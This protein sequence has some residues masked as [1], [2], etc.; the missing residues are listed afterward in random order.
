MNPCEPDMKQ[1]EPDMKQSTAPQSTREQVL[2]KAIDLTVTQREAVYGDPYPNL[3][4]AGALKALYAQAA[5]NKH[6]AAHN[7]A[8]DLLLTKVARI[9]TGAPG[10]TDNY[11]D[12]AAYF[13]LAAECAVR[14]AD[15]KQP[16]APGSYSE[17]GEGTQV[18][19]RGYAGVYR[20][21]SVHGGVFH[22][23]GVTHLNWCDA[24]KVTMAD[25][26]SVRS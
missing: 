12:G 8:I 19:L 15:V 26:D 13:A 10:H 17:I 24:K 11:V 3:A 18:K 25:I 7:A 6:C 1:D 5:G 14:E 23:I 4:L 20:V 21:V 22:V 2:R 9:A 16:A